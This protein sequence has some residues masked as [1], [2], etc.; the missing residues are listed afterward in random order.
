MALLKRGVVVGWNW[1]LLGG[2]PTSTDIAQNLG[3]V[4]FLPMALLGDRLGYHV[5]HAVMFVAIPV[6]LWWDLRDE[7]RDTRLVGTALGCFFA[8]GYSGPLGS[9]G[10]TNS[11]VGVCC[12]VLA[13]GAAT[14]RA[15]ASGGAGR[16]CCLG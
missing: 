4:G 3:T 9:S 12:A 5:L 1:G 15:A 11:L 6:F 2:Y 13:L 16:S 8:A 10:D 7:P 14:P